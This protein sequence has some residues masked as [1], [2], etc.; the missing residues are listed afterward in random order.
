MVCS[1]C[2][3]LLFCQ[4]YPSSDRQSGSSNYRTRQI[5]AEHAY[6]LS[7]LALCRLLASALGRQPCGPTGSR[8]RPPNPPRH[9]HYLDLFLGGASAIVFVLMCSTLS[10]PTAGSSQ[11]VR[12]SPVALDQAWMQWLLF[13]LLL[14]TYAVPSSSSSSYCAG[15]RASGGGPIGAAAE[16]SLQWSRVV[17]ALLRALVLGIGCMAFQLSLYQPSPLQRQQQEM[18]ASAHI[19]F[20]PIRRWGSMLHATAA[21]AASQEGWYTW[22]GIVSATLRLLIQIWAALHV[23]RWF[24]VLSS[25]VVERLRCVCAMSITFQLMHVKLR[26]RWC[27]YA[28][29]RLTG[30]TNTGSWTWTSTTSTIA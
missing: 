17:E 14:L 20:Q 28:H 18:H 8:S 3:F 26:Q 9:R 25:I 10:L 22:W 21:T 30:N 19:D 27:T 2:V 13:L 29:H 1:T 5:Y 24:A 23:A 7:L 6:T 4:G 11:T 12:Q 15:E 16:R